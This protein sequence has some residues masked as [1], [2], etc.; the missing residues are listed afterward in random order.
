MVLLRCGKAR[1]SAW[2]QEN[3]PEDILKTEFR[4]RLGVTDLNPS[5]YDVED[6]REALVQ[7]YAEHY[8]NAGLDLNPK[9]LP[10]QIHVTVS[11]AF[12]GHAKP[13]PEGLRFE[14]IRNAHREISFSNEQALLQF[15]ER[16]LERLNDVQRKTTRPQFRQYVEDRLAEMDPEWL[17]AIGDDPRWR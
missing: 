15:I 2:E 13:D 7:T 11:S 4:D 12:D 5:V 8:A 1:K 6:H 3:S 17:E 16:V 9:K 10:A 14:H